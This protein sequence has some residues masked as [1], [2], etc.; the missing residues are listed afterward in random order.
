MTDRRTLTRSRLRPAAAVLTAVAAGQASTD[1]R[2]GRDPLRGAALPL[3]LA[4]GWCVVRDAATRRPYL[5]YTR[6][7][8]GQSASTVTVPPGGLWCVDVTNAGDAGA[9]LVAVSYFATSSHGT[10]EADDALALRPLFDALELVDERDYLLMRITPAFGFAAS[11][12]QRLIE[13]PLHVAR[14]F[15]RLG[16]TLT[17]AGPYGERTALTVHVHPPQG[18]PADVP[19]AS[20]EGLA[21]AQQ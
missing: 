14:A 7:L 3:A 19:E 18:L 12:T 16:V 20:S 5:T 10:V 4:A 6:G 9:R 17:Y 11:A 1:V 13:L 21:G 15:S 8:H 2:R